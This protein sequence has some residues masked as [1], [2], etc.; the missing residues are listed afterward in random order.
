[1]KSEKYPVSRLRRPY[2]KP[3]DFAKCVKD[4]SD[5]Y[6]G[7]ATQRAECYTDLAR[8]MLALSKNEAAAY[9][10]DALEAVNRFGDELINR[11][12]S[13]TSLAVIAGE[14]SGSNPELAYKYARAAEVVSEHAPDHFPWDTVICNVAKIC[15]A[16]GFAV[17]SRWLDRD[18]GWIREMLP[19]LTLFLL[20]SDLISPEAAFSLLSFKG[21]WDIGEFSD[22]LFHKAKQKEYQ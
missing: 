2:R 3:Y 20:K 9:F 21:R 14:V 1:M 17:L 8:A 15:P 18:K 12:E 16:S 4:D 10:G 7:D 22:V 19:S 5:E 13:I 6:R 11:W